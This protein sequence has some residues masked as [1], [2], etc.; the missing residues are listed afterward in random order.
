M[1]VR[2][3][4]RTR[5]QRGG[6]SNEDNMEK[7]NIEMGNM[8]NLGEFPTRPSSPS[9]DSIGTLSRT[10]PVRNVVRPIDLGH[11]LRAEMSRSQTPEIK[12]S[13]P[14]SFS[15]TPS[16]VRR[17][18]NKSA[19]RRLSY[20]PT[21]IRGIVR[22]SATRR[23][24]IGG[25]RKTHPKSGFTFYSVQEHKEFMDGK[26]KTVRKEVN[27]KNGKGT[28]TVIMRNE[29][30]KTRRSTVQIGEHELEQIRRNVFV[31]G[32][33]RECLDNCK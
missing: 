25:K 30:G 19:N 29:K 1:P 17:L 23:L 6:D 9:D 3:K 7:V 10:S 22:N 31:P 20:T 16:N 21:K 14:F 24:T 28:K 2:R 12:K 4:Q 5:K 18:N 11:P 33:F 8:S 13:V 27:I 15:A 32:L 26:G